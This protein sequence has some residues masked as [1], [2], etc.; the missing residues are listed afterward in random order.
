M[1]Q[2][3]DAAV[4]VRQASPDDA[5]AIAR[6]HVRSWQAAYAGQLPEDL[7]RDLSVATRTEAWHRALAQPTAR[8]TTLVAECGNGVAGFVDTGPSRDDDADDSVGELSAIYVDPHCWGQGLGRAL[9]DQA[10]AIL[11]EHCTYATLWVLATNAR[12]RRFYE[13]AGWRVQGVEKTEQRGAATLE[14]VR[15]IR[16]IMQSRTSRPGP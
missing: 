3:D 8:R 10:I 11:A 7:L 12:A 5:A 13:R 4:V 1:R 9:H 14:E 16:S 2:L 15:Y 6:V